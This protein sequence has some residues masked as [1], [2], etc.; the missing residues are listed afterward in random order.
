MYG[1]TGRTATE[2]GR[3][4][5]TGQATLVASGGVTPTDLV[6]AAIERIEAVDGAVNA[7]IHRR[8]ERALAEAADPSLPTRPLRGVPLLLKDLGAASA[9][10][11]DQHGNRFLKDVG[12]VAERDATLIAL[13]R[14]A[15]FVV[16]GRTNTPAAATIAWRVPT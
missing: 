1:S 15:G 13:L 5:A 9:G 6:G 2:L 12:R 4:D 3:L 8:F 16:L 10:D 7:V 14:R 11:P